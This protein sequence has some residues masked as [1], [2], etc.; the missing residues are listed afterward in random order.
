MSTS[1][2]ARRDLNFFAD[3]PHKFF[4]DYPQK[5]WQQS[6][7]PLKNYYSD[8]LIAQKL[9]PLCFG[10]RNETHYLQEISRYCTRGF[11][12]RHTLRLQVI[13]CPGFHVRTLGYVPPAYQ[14]KRWSPTQG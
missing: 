5:S 2:R 6:V 9:Q 3:Y 12:V 13:Y 1:F 10:R 14:V 7:Y 4:A 8:R 11:K